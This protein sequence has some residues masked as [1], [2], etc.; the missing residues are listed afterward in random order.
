MRNIGTQLTYQIEFTANRNKSVLTIECLTAIIGKFKCKVYF[1][2][3][4]SCSFKHQR[5][6]LQS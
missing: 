1:L 5:T 2:T 3:S 4:L 6:V